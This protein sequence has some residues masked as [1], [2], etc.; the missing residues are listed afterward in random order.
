[1]LLY[2][3]FM[4]MFVHII[5][6]SFIFHGSYNGVFV[7]GNPTFP[8]TSVPTLG[9][10]SNPTSNPTIYTNSP[11]S[12]P[13]S[14]PTNPPTPFSISS[15]NYDNVLNEPTNMKIDIEISSVWDSIYEVII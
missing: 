15:L 11:S 2:K 7:A 13:S 3:Y 8:P 5:I 10:T 14:M 9:P 1:M 12:Q 4:A 6:V